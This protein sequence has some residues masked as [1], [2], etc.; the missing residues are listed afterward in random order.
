MTINTTLVVRHAL[1]QDSVDPNW[2]ELS[3]TPY[4]PPLAEQ[5]Y[6]QA[7]STGDVVGELL[8]NMEAN[9]S[10][11]TEGGDNLEGN[12]CLES[13]SQNQQH[14]YIHCSPFLRCV[15]T[16]ATIA[17]SIVKK[18]LSS[19]STSSLRRTSSF[20]VT[21]RIDAF[22]GEWLTPDYYNSI[23]PPPS[24]N[25]ESLR[26]SSLAWLS[27]DLSN[28]T[29]NKK[30]TLTN[31][32]PYINIDFTWDSSQMGHSGDYGESWAGMHSRLSNGLSKLS[33]YY[34]NNDKTNIDNSDKLLKILS[35]SNPLNLNLTSNPNSTDTLILVTH[36]AA[37]NPLLSTLLNLPVL[38]VIGLASYCLVSKYKRP[39]FANKDFSEKSFKSLTKSGDETNENQLNESVADFH[40]GDVSELPHNPTSQNAQIQAFST[41]TLNPSEISKLSKLSRIPKHRDG[42]LLIGESWKAVAAS[43][44]LIHLINAS[45]NNIN[46]MALNAI[47]NNTTPTTTA[48]NNNNTTFDIATNTYDLHSLQHN[49]HNRQHSHT[50]SGIYF[51]Q[52]STLHTHQH[53][54]GSL[55]S[56]L[57]SMFGASSKS[58][59]SYNLSSRVGSM[60]L[61]TDS[62]KSKSKSTSSSDSKSGI[63]NSGL[64]SSSD[65]IGSELISAPQA[66]FSAGS[67]SSSSNKQQKEDSR[68]KDNEITVS[69]KPIFSLH[70]KNSSEDF[71][72]GFSHSFSQGLS[73]PLKYSQDSST[74]TDLSHSYSDSNSNSY[75]YSNSNSNT[76][77][78]SNSWSSLDAI[79]VP[80][81]AEVTNYFNSGIS[82]PNN[83][84]AFNSITSGL[85]SLEQGQ[86]VR[87]DD[88]S[89]IRVVH[90]DDD[91][92]DGEALFPKFISKRDTEEH[93]FDV[94]TPVF[95]FNHNNYSNSNSL[96]SVSDVNQEEGSNS[97]TS[98][99]QELKKGSKFGVERADCRGGV[100]VVGTTSYVT[101]K[102]SDFS[103]PVSPQTPSFEVGNS[104]N[105]GD[106]DKNFNGKDNLDNQKH[107][108]GDNLKD[109]KNQSKAENENGFNGFAG[110]GYGYYD[111]GEFSSD[112][113]NYA[114]KNSYPTNNKNY[115][116]TKSGK[117]YDEGFKDEGVPETTQE[118]LD[119]LCVKQLGED[120]EWEETDGNEQTFGSH[121]FL[122]GSPQASHGFHS[123][124]SSLYSLL[125]LSFGNASND[126]SG[127]NSI[128]GEQVTT[129]SNTQQE[130]G[131]QYTPSNFIAN[132]CKPST[133][134]SSSS[135][136]GPPH[137]SSSGINLNRQLGPEL[138]L[139]F[140]SLPP[141]SEA[142]YFDPIYMFGGNQ[143]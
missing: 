41:T 6:G 142:S 39:V 10:G 119:L 101:Q 80:S 38:S 17:K 44:D 63:F 2:P 72:Q 92:D 83:M 133:L 76:N 87:R 79:S 62:S 59:S 31:I 127:K 111:D 91:D 7:G 30:T 8:V 126:A 26:L 49:R 137:L 139:Q 25:H 88:D 34:N 97:I 102:W 143:L 53:H 103:K 66:F 14:I 122:S 29:N 56:N 37:C 73:V 22:L 24:D 40:T 132:T 46:N 28:T 78:N 138:Q 60:V 130:S 136:P 77:S 54:E 128:G 61:F 12:D 47:L 140:Q 74:L 23:M 50:I 121:H 52:P 57:S 11:E 104:K 58:A 27:K 32:T 99:N 43:S 36:G 67:S 68:K 35:A 1:R 48:T 141:K 86:G 89:E 113:K 125:L 108:E 65:D 71:S 19:S 95:G 18:R 96:A 115:A 123:S 81:F 93:E 134:S 33:N 4:D 70:S 90:D 55:S 100:G 21:I 131:Q 98:P 64:S 16:A 75:S 105:N 109:R 117:N 118:T 20:K 116:T 107:G 114:T 110:G 9:V 51:N 82:T 124:S 85:K 5:G 106:D 3:P 13:Q 45:E 135:S 15:Q 69:K 120:G 42:N 129:G 94:S 112:D 84:S